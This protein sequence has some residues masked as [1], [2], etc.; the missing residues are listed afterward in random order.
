MR[1][2]AQGIG[3]RMTRGQAISKTLQTPESQ[4]RLTKA[5]R[6]VWASYTPRQRARRIAAMTYAVNRPDILH[7]KSLATKRAFRDLKAKQRLI[8][9][10]HRSLTLKKRKN[11]S[12][13]AKRGW[14]DPEIRAKHLK[15][16]MTIKGGAGQPPAVFVKKLAMILEPLGYVREFAI[17]DISVKRTPKGQWP[18]RKLMY[19]MADFALPSRKISIECDGPH[20]NSF[21][22]KAIDKRR[23]KALRRLGWKVIRVPHD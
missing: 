18:G 7:K 9:G 5:Q 10:I 23:D 20:H 14:S 16:G 8:R 6:G 11:L 3:A 13:A 1:T 19:Y 12:D 21:A 4:R 17:K 22:Q 15:H 2:V